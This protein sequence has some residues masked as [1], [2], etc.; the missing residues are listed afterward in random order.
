MILVREL[1]QELFQEPSQEQG[2]P[3]LQSEQG[4]GV[5]VLNRHERQHLA[6]AGFPLREFQGDRLR[7]RR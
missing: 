7:V 2:V 1:V 5:E 3:H 4:S 6:E